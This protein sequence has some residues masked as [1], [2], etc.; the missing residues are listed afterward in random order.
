MTAA[1]RRGVW[2]EHRV[3]VAGNEALRRV[4]DEMTNL[5]IYGDDR[6]PR[7]LAMA[8]EVLALWPVRDLSAVD[9]S[10]V[11]DDRDLAAAVRLVQESDGRPP[12]L[13][14]MAAAAHLSRRHFTRRFRDH[15]GCSPRDFANAHRLARA[16]ELLAGGNA[17]AGA[18]GAAVGFAHAPAFNRWFARHVGQTPDQFRRDPHVA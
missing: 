16:K 15:F 8:A 5:P 12:T 3:N 6:P 2:A 7:L 9:A 10:A 14:A 17:T 11:D 4:A 13:D 1:L 18:T